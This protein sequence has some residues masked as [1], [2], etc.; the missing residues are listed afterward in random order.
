MLVGNAGEAGGF[1]RCTYIPENS[2]HLV[3]I[4]GISGN[5]YNGDTVRLPNTAYL[6]LNEQL[7]VWIAR[8]VST[9]AALRRA[10]YERRS[11]PS[12][13]LQES[14]P[15]KKR[16][17]DF[18]AELKA[19]AAEFEDNHE[20]YRY[21]PSEDSIE[22]E[23]DTMLKCGVRPRKRK[24]CYEFSSSDEDG[25]GVF[26][27]SGR[28]RARKRQRQAASAGVWDSLPPIEPTAYPRKPIRK[29][30]RPAANS[31]TLTFEEIKARITQTPVVLNEPSF[32]IIVMTML[33]RAFPL[34][35]HVNGDYES[36]RGH[37]EKEREFFPKSTMKYQIAAGEAFD[38][39]TQEDYFELHRKLMA[40]K[41]RRRVAT[42]QVH[43]KASYLE[44][45]Q[46]AIRGF[47]DDSLRQMYISPILPDGG[48]NLP[49]GNFVER[50][51]PHG[52]LVTWCKNEGGPIFTPSEQNPITNEDD[53]N[54]MY[55]AAAA[56]EYPML[57]VITTLDFEDK[58]GVGS[59]FSVNIE[60]G[61]FLT[62]YKQGARNATVEIIRNDSAGKAVL[63][64]TIIRTAYFGVLS[65]GALPRIAQHLIGTSKAMK[66]TVGNT[67]PLV[68]EGE[69]DAMM[70]KWRPQPERISLR[71]TCTVSLKYRSYGHGAADNQ[72]GYSAK[73]SGREHEFGVRGWRRFTQCAG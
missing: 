1:A 59:P 49:Y 48:W 57:Q 34:P 66:V 69:F 63:N 8:P 44:G 18:A 15:L 56:S 13:P 7:W 45:I 53:L 31:G 25:H 29:I 36:I 52:E 70:S 24:L 67:R 41:P 28:A 11:A 22:E 21:E 14:I 64:P 10:E 62:D 47:T 27:R 20:D 35:S 17:A 55:Y 6:R 61:R 71:I 60:S 33:G 58:N 51:S 72:L 2:R 50:Y 26:D 38:F 43:L 23:D 46:F 65:W 16:A 9:Y 40:L 73:E 19:K 3:E 32:E 30:M 12:M 37:L 68:N 4:M 42:I 54:A 39:N 5:A